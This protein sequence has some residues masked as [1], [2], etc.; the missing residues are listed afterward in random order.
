MASAEVSRADAEGKIG[1]D[2]NEPGQM[3]LARDDAR[4]AQRGKKAA[5][6][7]VQYSKR[8]ASSQAAQVTAAERK[9]DLMTEK[10]NVAKLQALDD[11]A[12]PAGGKYDH[13]GAMRRVVDA[14]RAYDSA[15]AAADAAVRETTTAKQQWQELDEKR[16]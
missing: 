12:V 1:K 11:A 9:V 16:M 6:A 8:L 3:Q 15:T 14:Q 13:A 4:T 10:L 2:S 5:D 7:H